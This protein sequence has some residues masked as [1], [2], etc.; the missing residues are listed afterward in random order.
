MLPLA[1]PADVFIDG[2]THN[3]LKSN[4]EHETVI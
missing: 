2:T 3:L 4:I 1:K